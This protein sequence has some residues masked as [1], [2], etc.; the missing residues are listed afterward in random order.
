MGMPTWL[1][2]FNFF[3]FLDL[4]NFLP[5]FISVGVGLRHL[6]GLPFHGLTSCNQILKWVSNYCQVCGKVDESE[7]LSTLKHLMFLFILVAIVFGGS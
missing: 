4:Y 1:S 6:G 2:L 3:L 7:L 5:L